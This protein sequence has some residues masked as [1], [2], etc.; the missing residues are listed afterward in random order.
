MICV[1]GQDS[2]VK[3]WIVSTEVDKWILNTV[4]SELQ[5]TIRALAFRQIRKDLESKEDIFSKG[6][7][8]KKGNV[9]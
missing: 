4:E 5:L 1:G 6:F 7:T 2:V 9:I 8:F 3:H